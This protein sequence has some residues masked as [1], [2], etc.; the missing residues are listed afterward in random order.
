[1]DIVIDRRDGRSRFDRQR[2]RRRGRQTRRSPLLR[3]VIVVVII[4]TVAVVI[5]V[6]VVVVVVMDGRVGPLVFEL[7]SSYEGCA[8]ERWDIWRGML[9]LLLDR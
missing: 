2:C 5:I 4:A 9:L 3:L 8:G 1:M 6:V 7:Q